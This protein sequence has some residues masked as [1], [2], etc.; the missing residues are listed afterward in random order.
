MLA[1]LEGDKT[2]KKLERAINILCVDLKRKLKPKEV[3]YLAMAAKKF[4]GNL[5]GFYEMSIMRT[6]LVS[7]FCKVCKLTTADLPASHLH[8]LAFG[9]NG[10]SPH[11]RGFRQ[12]PFGLKTPHIEDCLTTKNYGSRLFKKLRKTKE[13]KCSICCY[14]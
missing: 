7:R 1:I 8:W 11:L 9:G 12:S 10:N 14:L 4:W 13:F 6:V 5:E 3:I 2:F